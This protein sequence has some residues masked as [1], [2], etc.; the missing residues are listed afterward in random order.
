M[1]GAVEHDLDV[2]LSAGFFDRWLRKPLWV[3][4]P[5][6]EAVLEESTVYYAENPRPASQRLLVGQPF[7]ALSHVDHP[8]EQPPHEIKLNNKGREVI[9]VALQWVQGADDSAFMDMYNTDSAGSMA[10]AERRLPRFPIGKSFL[11]R[12]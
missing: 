11:T 5:G 12:T 2:D 7:I 1:T 3:L 8:F 10:F 6:S 4:N 9:R